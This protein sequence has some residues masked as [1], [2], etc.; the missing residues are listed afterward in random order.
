ME[1]SVFART[2][3]S[4]T[5]VEIDKQLCDTLEVRAKRLRERGLRDFRVVCGDFPNF[6]KDADVFIW[7][8]HPHMARD[9]SNWRILQD[10]ARLQDEGKIRK[11][12]EAV[13]LMESTYVRNGVRDWRN[14]RRWST[15][16]Q[17]FKFNLYDLC[18][19]LHPDLGCLRGKEGLMVVMSMSIR[20]VPRRV[21]Q[22][23]LWRGYGRS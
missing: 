7:W 12:A 16:S 8:D 3:S 21:W 23:A 17:M 1:L 18:M 10:L 4:A 14:L 6:Y 11:N 13:F 20:N 19:E 15:W 5:A 2:A 22:L 9:F